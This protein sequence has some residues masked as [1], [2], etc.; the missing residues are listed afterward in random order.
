MSCF[1]VSHSDTCLFFYTPFF[2][3]SR[4]LPEHN[5]LRGQ[6]WGYSIPIFS[7]TSLLLFIRI[8]YS[9]ANRVGGYHT[10]IHQS[11][12][13]LNY[14]KPKSCKRHQ[15]ILHKPLE[16]RYYKSKC[17]HNEGFKQQRQEELCKTN[18]IALKY[19]RDG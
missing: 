19:L 17:L 6:G 8:S 10:T 3:L 18:K 14:A 16:F 9:Y 2:F 4:A 15:F 5:T 1:L 11:A 7:S 13:I 12:K